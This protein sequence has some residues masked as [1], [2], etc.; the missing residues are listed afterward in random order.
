M[1]Q[2]LQDEP[3]NWFRFRVQRLW[4][5]VVPEIL[6]SPFRRKR[7]SRWWRWCACYGMRSFF[8]NSLKQ[9]CKKIMLNCINTTAY[10]LLPVRI[11]NI[12]GISC[13]SLC[14]N[15]AFLL[16]S[17]PSLGAP[18]SSDVVW[19]K[20]SPSMVDELF[21]DETCTKTSLKKSGYFCGQSDLAIWTTN[22]TAYKKVNITNRLLKLWLI[23]LVTNEVRGKQ[24]LF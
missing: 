17:R 21:E 2:T 4:I 1:S 24:M 16:E 11:A 18:S 10:T 13:N 5:T 12:W 23:Y 14:F 6:R 15:S 8:P 20:R 7:I 3:S 22:C 9:S 19:R